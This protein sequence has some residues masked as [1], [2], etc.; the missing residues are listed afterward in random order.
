MSHP[1]PRL[2]VLGLL[3]LGASGCSGSAAPDPAPQAPAPPGTP[4]PT[5]PQA[6]AP[7]PAPIEIPASLALSPAGREAVQTLARTSYFGGWAVGAA[8]TP[9]ETVRAWRVVL[10]EPTATESFVLVLERGT[11]A[12]KLM[13][14]AG[15]HRT[16]R[17]R[18]DRELPAFR[19]RPGTVSVMTSGCDPGGDPEPIA[20]VVERPDGVRLSGPDDNLFL[21]SQRNPGR[22]IHFDLAGGSYTAVMLPRPG[23]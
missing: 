14:L 10:A 11:D 21:W 23:R 8:G 2:A 22:P 7:P 13:A 12:G 9:T 18:F 16:D 3:V 1:S 20:A 17:A 19:A 5:A 15:L 6:P 4:G